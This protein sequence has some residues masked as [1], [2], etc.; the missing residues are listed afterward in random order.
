MLFFDRRPAS[1]T[2]WT[3]EMWVYDLRTNQHFTLKEKPLRQDDLTDFVACY[4]PGDRSKRVESERFR[5]FSYDELIKRNKAG[6]DIFWRRDESLEDADNLPP[7]E[8][9]GSSR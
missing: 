4:Q 1:E 5:S 6:L 9:I 8:I 2:P 3:K 7:P